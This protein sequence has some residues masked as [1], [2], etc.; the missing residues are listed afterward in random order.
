MKPSLLIAL[1]TL[2]A[3]VAAG[4][5]EREGADDAGEAAIREA[6]LRAA[7]DTGAPSYSFSVLGAERVP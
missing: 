4:C 2:C 3:L 1:I 7:A 6:R 5:G